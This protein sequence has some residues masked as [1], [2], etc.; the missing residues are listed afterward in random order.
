[1]KSIVVR[2]TANG[3]E[4]G[5]IRSFP[6]EDRT[7]GFQHMKPEVKERCLKEQKENAKIVNM[8]YKSKEEGGYLE[9]PFCLGG[10]YPIEYWRFIDNY[11]YV[12]A[13]IH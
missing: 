2:T 1:M 6:N 7:D 4:H 12:C 9:M 3:I 10:G 11:I 8:M 5:M 13:Y